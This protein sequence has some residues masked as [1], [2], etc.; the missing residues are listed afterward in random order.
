MQVS[1]GLEH[2]EGCRKKQ[3]LQNPIMFL[4]FPPQKQKKEG[5]MKN[6]GV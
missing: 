2:M 4:Q 6:E 1:G 3:A 5:K